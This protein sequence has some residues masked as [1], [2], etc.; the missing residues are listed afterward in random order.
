MGQLTSILPSFT[1]VGKGGKV[2]LFI[3]LVQTAKMEFNFYDGCEEEIEKIVQKC[4]EL[5]V[6]FLRLTYCDTN[7]IG[8]CKMVSM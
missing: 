2:R 8:R 3:Q 6:Q 5:K 7:G 4:Q 1:V